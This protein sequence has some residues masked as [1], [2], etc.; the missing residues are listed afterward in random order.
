[1]NLKEIQ[2]LVELWEHKNQQSNNQLTNIALLTE[3]VG[4]LTRLIAQDYGKSTLSKKD[5]ERISKSL[6]EIIWR[7]LSIANQ[8]GINTSES[9]IATL[10]KKNKEQ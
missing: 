4:E 5:K 2:E 7:T 1:M 8:S 9:I 3:L 10:E 6:G